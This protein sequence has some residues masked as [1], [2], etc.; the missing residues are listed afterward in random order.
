MRAGLRSAPELGLLLHAT[1][2]LACELWLQLH[3][4]SAYLLSLC[5]ASNAAD[6]I[7]GC[8]QSMAQSREQLAAQPAC[9]VRP[10]SLHTPALTP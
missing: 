1:A 8:L 6:L 3:G 7:L 5:S 9:S 10:L 4:V 2:A